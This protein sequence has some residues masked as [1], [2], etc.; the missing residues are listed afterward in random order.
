MPDCSCVVCQ[1]ACE[2]MFGKPGRFLPDELEKAAALKNLSVQE[3]FNKY[4]GVEG[5]LFDHEDVFF[6]IT[7]AITAMTPGAEYPAYPR[8]QC[9]FYKDGKCDIHDAKPYECRETLC[10]AELRDTERSVAAQ[11]TRQ[12]TLITQWNL[13]DSQRLVRKLLGRAPAPRPITPAELRKFRE[14]HRMRS[15]DTAL[16]KLAET[17]TDLLEKLHA[18]KDQT[19]T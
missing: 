14:W 17:L 7:P 13:I 9:V 8:G 19:G 5:P 1:S 16:W 10:C 12:D 2:A 6:W 15:Q 4:C 18:S 11:Q 3:F